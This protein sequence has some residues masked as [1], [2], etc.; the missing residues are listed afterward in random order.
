MHSPMSPRIM[1]DYTPRGK[2]F[3]W[4]TFAVG[5]V[6]IAWSVFQLSAVPTADQSQI[7]VGLAI[8]ALAFIGSASIS[9]MLYATQEAFGATAIMVGVPVIAIFQTMLH[10]FFRQGELNERLRLEKLAA[11][12]RQRAEAARHIEELQHIADHDG[13]TNLPNR[14]Y[15]FR[16]LE[17]VVSAHQ[18]EPTHRFAVMMLDFDRF[19]TIN[20]SLGHGAVTSC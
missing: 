1:E 10:L 9:G 16:E 6:V 7:I 11:T 14:R 18:R 12:E 17:R 5:T 4:A 19:K 15:F 3:W 2:A 13:L 8:A 20:D